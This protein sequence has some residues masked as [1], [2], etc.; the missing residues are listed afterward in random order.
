MRLVTLRGLVS[1][2]SRVQRLP[3]L[4]VA[5]L[6]MAV[7]VV[8]IR[9]ALP[10]YGGPVAGLL[11]DPSGT[12][13]SLG[14]PDWDGHRQGLRF[15]DRVL[16]I[17]SRDLRGIAPPSRGK[18]WNEALLEAQARGTTRVV[19]V[20][21]HDQTE[22]RVELGLHSMEGGAWW[23]LGGGFVLVGLL[24]VG[25]ALVA[26]WASPRGRLA[27]SFAKVATLSGIHLLTLFDLHTSRALVPVF[28]F[29]FAL[30]PG[31]FAIVALR[32]PDDAPVLRRHP[33]L[34]KA[35]DAAGLI[36]AAGLIGFHVTGRDTE[37]LQ[38]VL[39]R[40]F[41]AA[42]GFFV[43]TFLIRFLLARGERRVILKALLF[44]MLPPYAVVAAWGVLGHRIATTGTAQL[45]AFIGQAIAP[46]G[47]LYA[48][49][50][51]DLWGS[52]ALLS[53]VLTQAFVGSL[54]CAAAVALGAEVAH[55]LGVPFQ[56][57]LI[58]AF[59]GAVPAAALLAVALRLVERGLFR[60]RAAYK[61]TIDELSQELTS[62]HSVDA[63]ARA[64]E[65]TVT[66]WLACEFIEVVLEAPERWLAQRASDSGE[67]WPRFSSEV[68]PHRMQQGEPSQTPLET[69]DR[70]GRS[71]A[72]ELPISFDGRRLG[73]LIVGNKR[74]GALFTDDDVDLLRTIANQGALA[75]AHARA[76]E[77]LE[78]RR[79]QQ[80]AAWR[81]ER[82]A[83]V[84]TMAS[85]LAHE[86]QHPLSFFR[87]VFGSAARGQKLDEK[88]ISVGRLEIERLERLFDGLKRL[89]AQRIV[90]NPVALRELCA[91]AKVLLVDALGDRR[92]TIE[93][94]QTVTLD[95]DADKTIQ[96]LVNLL[97]NAIDA[98]GAQG[99]IGIAWRLTPSGGDIEVW[100]EGAG[101]VG[102]PNRLFDAWYTTKP[103]GTGLGLSIVH[104]LLRTHGWTIT[105]SR[106]EVRTVFTISV[107]ERDVVRVSQGTASGTFERVA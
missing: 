12:V 35:T 83:L 87:R 51:H 93:V 4:V 19:A 86:M 37:P 27:R 62:I 45:T 105:P 43:V 106:R 68:V 80:A 38:A 71:A 65:R 31:G 3:L 32:L 77:E 97:S 72:L 33:W 104:R 54:V 17:E 63:V 85:E 26:L 36:F 103:R 79:R 96:V 50:R 6:A 18:A 81:Y 9:N 49:V 73:A 101:Y 42:F 16:Q 15:P 69:L 92:C 47:T 48:F 89:S 11:V 29:T 59:C 95:C 78:Q 98:A 91:R 58:A 66:R 41:G 107:P 74:G 94:D 46:L 8:A 44:G 28:F 61:P 21:T 70:K 2:A 52:R 40:V 20:V 64:V 84:I 56:Y 75:L 1:R 5:T 22:R 67:S 99:E 14:L 57:A 13:S 30:L 76:Y 82:E 88:Q 100:D 60:S 55:R 23:V 10:W 34:E 39:T 24:Y 25:A 102:D 7:A 90:R 53:R